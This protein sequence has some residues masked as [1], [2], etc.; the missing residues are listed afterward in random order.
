MAD[1]CFCFFSQT[2]TLL[3]G[4]CSDWQPQ[5]LWER[6]TERGQDPCP[7]WNVLPMTPPPLWSGI[8]G[9]WTDFFPKPQHVTAFKSHSAALCTLLMSHSQ[10]VKQ[11]VLALKGNIIW[12]FKNHSGYQRHIPSKQVNGTKLNLPQLGL[13]TQTLPVPIP[14]L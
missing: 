13:L 12:C 5:M 11:T 2:A 7:W 8:W 3:S 10:H 6:W 1:H 14:W 4:S 9:E